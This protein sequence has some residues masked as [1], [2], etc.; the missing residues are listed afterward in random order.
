VAVAD[1]DEEEAAALDAA[2]SA[3][4]EIGEEGDGASMTIDADCIVDS[5]NSSL[6]IVPVERNAAAARR[7][8]LFFFRGE[9]E[10]ER[11]RAQKSG[12]RKSF[13]WR[14]SSRTKRV[15]SLF[16]TSS[17]FSSIKNLL[18]AQG[19]NSKPTTEIERK[20]LRTKLY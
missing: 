17:T 12:T 13:A 18:D 3:R 9:R 6:L 8:M 1:D 14:L 10:R 15:L 16:S 4:R 7:I 5:L 2:R 20:H 11:E 19:V